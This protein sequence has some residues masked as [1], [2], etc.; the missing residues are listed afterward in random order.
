M[1]YEQFLAIIKDLAKSQGRYGRMLEAL[2]DK[3][4]EEKRDIETYLK[5]NNINNAVD[6]ILAIE[7]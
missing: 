7:G 6:L 5:D 2:Q 3:T 1:K 4:D